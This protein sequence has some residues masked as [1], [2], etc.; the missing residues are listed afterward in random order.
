MEQTISENVD[1]DPLFLPH[2]EKKIVV[3]KYD[4]NTS[5]DELENFPAKILVRSRLL[6]L[7]EFKR[8]LVYQNLKK[9][10][11][12]PTSIILES[13]LENFNKFNGH[14]INYLLLHCV[15]YKKKNEIWLYVNNKSVC[16]VLRELH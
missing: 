5:L 14:M 16:F 2:Y 1:D 9:R 3:D 7:V 4:M 10:S 8:T 11:R 6:L 12:D 15:T 13:C